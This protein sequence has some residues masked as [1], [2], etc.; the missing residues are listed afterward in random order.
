M[1]NTNTEITT[2]EIT[3]TEAAPVAPKITLAAVVR[4]ILKKVRKG[5]SVTV[6]KVVEEAK[7]L[8]AEQGVEAV[9][10][11]RSVFR[12]LSSNAT[13]VTGSKGTFTRKEIK[14]TADTA[15][16]ENTEEVASTAEMVAA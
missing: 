4:Q 6:S 16:A 13:A 12:A 9:I 2:T 7:V 15:P 11:Y 5:R 8:A 1:K 3:T 14:E 10:N